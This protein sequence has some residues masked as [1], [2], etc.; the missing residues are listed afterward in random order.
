MRGIRLKAIAAKAGA[1]VQAA[2]VRAI[3][4]ELIIDKAR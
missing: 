4:M 2:M 3:C 1:A